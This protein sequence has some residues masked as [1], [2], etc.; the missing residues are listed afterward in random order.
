MGRHLFTGVLL[1]VGGTGIV[2]SSVWAQTDYD[3]LIKGGHVIDGKNS[4]SAVRDVAIK[5]GKIAAVAPNIAASLALKT[6]DAS[7]LYVTPG[8][9][10]IHVHV[11]PGLIRNSYA[12]GSWGLQPDGFT[13]R[14]GVTTVAD[15]GS[16]GWRN[17]EDF[18]T[19]IIDTQKTRVLSFLNIVGAGMGSGQIEQNL[20][21]MEVKPAADTALKYK[22]I[23]VGIKSAHFNG[24][25][26]TPYINAEEVGKIAHIPVMVDFGGNVRAG[27]TLYDLLNKYF[28]AGDIFTHMYGGHRGEQDP[29]TKGPSKAMLDGRKR[30]VIF[31]VGHGGG[32]FLWSCAIPL[33]KAGFIPDS[34]STDLHYSSMNA[35]MKDMLNV[36]DKFLALGM[37][38]DEVILRSTW[39]P[40][41]EIQHEELGNLSVGAPADV[42]VLRLEKGRFGFVDQIGGRLDGA[43]RLLCEMTLRAGT[44]VYDLNGL[45]SVPWEKVPP[46][47]PGRGGRGQGGADAATPRKDAK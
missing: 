45:T 44:V 42:T 9:V 43:E 24:P 23:I 39:N 15:A 3:L 20:E 47:A 21:D 30:G 1:V 38:L 4:I 7:G 35:G 5:D 46:R 33:M 8:L 37:P 31:D 10:D 17:F 16:S 27:R 41:K 11:Y 18:K 12:A 13:L 14:A 32:S 29:D 6:V 22:G 19:R 34:I 36:M 40:A 26:W 2:P 25:E 28:R